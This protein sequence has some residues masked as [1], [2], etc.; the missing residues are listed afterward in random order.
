[1]YTC[2]A[3]HL[4]QLTPNTKVGAQFQRCAMKKASNSHF[5]TRHPKYIAYADQNSK[6]L[7]VVMRK[8]TEQQI[9]KCVKC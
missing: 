5:L 8:Q 9:H 2:I 4:P 7:K 1:M 6:L 3:C